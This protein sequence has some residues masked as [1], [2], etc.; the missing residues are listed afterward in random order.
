MNT[1]TSYIHWYRKTCSVAGA[2][3]EIG[4]GDTSAYWILSIKLMKLF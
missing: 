3:L 2:S 4:F 1:D